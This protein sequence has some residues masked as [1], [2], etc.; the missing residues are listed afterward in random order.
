MVVE[1]WRRKKENQKKSMI[2]RRNRKST[3]NIKNNC[4]S[5]II[6]NKHCKSNK[7][8]KFVPLFKDNVSAFDND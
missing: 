4:K 2:D 3:R 1:F 5:L 6:N 8:M 7:N